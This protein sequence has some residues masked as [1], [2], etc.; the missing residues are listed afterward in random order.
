MG[1]GPEIVWAIGRQGTWE[2]EG[3]EFRITY[4]FSDG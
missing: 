3:P 2:G 1:S 4:M